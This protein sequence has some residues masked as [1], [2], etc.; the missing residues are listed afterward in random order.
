MSVLSPQPLACIELV[1]LVTDYLEGALD[2][3]T[4][5]RFEAHIA[6]CEHCTAYLE[7]MRETI[8]ITGRLREDALEP[9][10]REELLAAFRDWKAE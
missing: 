3:R 2:R 6:G 1:E 5:R 8:R 10:A 4:R 7:Q 9:R